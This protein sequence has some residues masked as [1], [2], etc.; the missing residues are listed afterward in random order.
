MHTPPRIRGGTTARYLALLSGLFLFAVAIVFQLE[1]RLGLSPWDTLHQG[2]A[3]HTPLSFGVANICVGLVVL[4]AAWALGASIG[5][6]TAANVI[7][8][9][10]FIQGLTAIPAVDHLSNDPLATRVGLLA[11]SMPL[12]GIATALYIGAWL[13]AGPRDSLMVVLGRRTGI[14]L[15]VVRAAIE[16]AALGAGWA[17]GGTVGVGTVVFA[18]GIGPA[19]EGGFWLVRR[20]PIGE[21]FTPLPAPLAGS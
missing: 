21:P 7:L 20:S 11:V 16:L 2:I 5:I 18:L 15:G 1:S 17:L 13:G 9:G 10:L 14:R 8:V 4:G 6:G 19:V 3:R 12:I